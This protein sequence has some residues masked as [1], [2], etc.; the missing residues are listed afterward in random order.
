MKTKSI[1]HSQLKPGDRV[2]L[3]SFHPDQRLPMTI[4]RIQR[5]ISQFT[6]V[7]RTRVFYDDPH[8]GGF[9]TWATFHD[10]L[11]NLPADRAD[12]LID[13]APNQPTTP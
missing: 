2:M 7:G 6:G 10:K 5:G 12:I 1:P 3:W 13:H 4:K 11:N 8:C 9:E